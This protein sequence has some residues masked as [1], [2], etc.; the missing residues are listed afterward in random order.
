MIA[1]AVAT[2]DYLWIMVIIVFAAGVTAVAGFGFGLLAVPFMALVIDLHSSVVISTILALLSN[3]FQ[4]VR[5]GHQR[6]P[7]VTSRMC[8]ASL[9]GAPFGFF[10]YDLVSDGALR[11]I[12]AAVIVVA[13]VALIRG[14]NLAHV[15]N[16]LDLGAGFV[17]GV[18]ATSLGTSGPPVVLGMQARHLPA[19]QVRSSLPIIF[20]VSGLLAATIFGA[21]GKIGRQ[22]LSLCAVAVPSVGVGLML[23]S[24]LRSRFNQESFRILVYVLMLITAISSAA[25][26]F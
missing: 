3:G 17:A 11:L 20:F 16:S 21:T 19:E 24:P 7:G 12:L 22:E 8:I 18:L 23:G 26:A 9:V 2:S 4:V 15:G 14:L 10:V 25:K 13:V 5:Y 1:E 6:A